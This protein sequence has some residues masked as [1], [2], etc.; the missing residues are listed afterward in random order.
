MAAENLILGLTGGIASGKSAVAA[1][2]VARGFRLIDAD[3]LARAVVEPG[4]PALA[5]IERHFGPQVLL[6]EGRLNRALLGRIVFSDPG[7][8]A[9]LN[10]ITHPRIGERIEQRLAEPASGTEPIL[11]DH[12][13]LY[14]TGQDRLVQ[15]VAVV[16]LDRATQLERLMAR[17]GLSLEEAVLRVEAQMDLDAK[18]AR[19]DFVIDNRGSMEQT[20]RQVEAICRRL[21]S[22]T[23]EDP[24]GIAARPPTDG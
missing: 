7:E 8:L 5:E 3:V 18:A 11:L 6:P 4:Q 17:N 1:L 20:E 14:E 22:G 21:R 13:L 2:F 15:K 24:Q 9:V 12:P 23:A 10:S 19:A 16:W